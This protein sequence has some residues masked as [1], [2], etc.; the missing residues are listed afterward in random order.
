M[1]L[2]VFQLRKIFG[3]N[4]GFL[5]GGGFH[6]TRKLFHGSLTAQNRAKA[7]AARAA[8][9]FLDPGSGVGGPGAA[10]RGPGAGRR[11]HLV[12]GLVDQVARAADLVCM[13]MHTRA[14]RRA[15]G[16]AAWSTRWVI[17]GART[18][19]QLAKARGLARP[20]AG[21]VG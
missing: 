8:A 5:E 17:P 16:A 15:P 14:T 18:T 4:R 10:V 6:G 1:E 13:Y 19:G 11:G 21:L 20:A 7:R 9:R 2:I 3:P 12:G